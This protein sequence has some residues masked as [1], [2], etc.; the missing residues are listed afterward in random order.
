M[1][2]G[3]KKYLGQLK[4]YSW[5]KSKVNELNNSGSDLNQLQNCQK[6]YNSK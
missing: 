5:R 4:Y 2:Y 6:T 3:S 1:W